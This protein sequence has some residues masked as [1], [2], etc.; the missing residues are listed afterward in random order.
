MNE[1]LRDRKKRLL[2][3]QISDVATGMFL[4]RGFDEVRVGEI[5][6][7]CDVSE[8]TV[9]NY[10]PTK[11]SLIFD[12]EEDQALQI[13]NAILGSRGVPLIDAVLAVLDADTRA[14]HTQWDAGADAK[15]QLG[16]LRRFAAMIED[17]PA[18]SAAMNAMTERLT[19]VAAVALAERAG[20]DPDDPEPQIAATLILGLWRVQFLAM[21]R[22][23][24]DSRT[25]NEFTESVLGD[26]R[27]AAAVANGGLASFN[28]VVGSS[29]STD[30]MHEA[31]AAA[32]Q[33][34]RQVIA[35]VKQARVA[36]RHVMAEVQR[37]HQHEH[38]M[39]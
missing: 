32:E 19:Q 27:R 29:N 33:A 16:T 34:R 18:L 11:E 24:D 13:G 21:L 3:Q 22:Y 14:M 1:G 15:E 17:T 35:A 4:E 20:V 39:H 10:F 2:R 36:W 37:H 28:I 25:I 23:A 30:G 5:A 26:I 7:A 6:A 38:D 31:A 9:Y 12:R 8:K